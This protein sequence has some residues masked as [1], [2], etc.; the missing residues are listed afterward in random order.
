V[1]LFEK[2]REKNIIAVLDTGTRFHSILIS[3]A[4][5]IRLRQDFDCCP[6]SSTHLCTRVGR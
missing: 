3:L 2:A 6:P 4:N 5:R 1:E